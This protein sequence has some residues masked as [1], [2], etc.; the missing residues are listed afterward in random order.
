M[1]KNDRK[2]SVEVDIETT[3]AIGMDVRINFTRTTKVGRENYGADADGNR[4]MM[5]DMIDDD[6]WSNVKVFFDEDTL[7]VLLADT[8]AKA[9]IEKIIEDW[10][11]AHEPVAPEEPEEDCDDREEDE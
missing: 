7:G 9:E 5:M 11:E 8:S 2:F 4:G 1:R 10:M 6:E 3:L